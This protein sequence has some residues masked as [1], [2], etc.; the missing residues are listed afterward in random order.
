MSRRQNLRNLDRRSPSRG[1]IKRILVVS[2]GTVTEKIYFEGLREFHKLNNICIKIEVQAKSPL[3]VVEWALKRPSIPECHSVWI[4]FDKDDFSADQVQQAIALIHAQPGSKVHC[5]FSNPCFDLWLLLHFENGAGAITRP[6]IYKRLRK[7]VDYYHQETNKK[8]FYRDF[9][10]GIVAAIERAKKI[11]S[12]HYSGG[13]QPPP[14][15]C[16]WRLLSEILGS[17]ANQPC[18][19]DGRKCVAAI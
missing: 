10:D 7:H 8:V 2:Q 5:A 17:P 1:R 11:D 6:E 15:T 12:V 16:V 13:T 19:R 14:S 9:K 18:Q 4:L 3:Q